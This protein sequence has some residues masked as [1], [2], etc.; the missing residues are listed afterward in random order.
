MR[1]ARR[2]PLTAPVHVR[3]QLQPP[4]SG[5]RPRPAKQRRR[6]C[7]TP[8][9]SNGGRAAGAGAAGWMALSESHAWRSLRTWSVLR[10]ARCEARQPV[11]RRAS[12]HAST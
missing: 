1:H 10:I 2:Q 11:G 7:R 4:A 12:M 3:E 9:E 8:A 5:A 6:L